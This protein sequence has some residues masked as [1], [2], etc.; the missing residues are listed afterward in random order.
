MD[1]YT[2]TMVTIITVCVFCSSLWVASWSL[3]FGGHNHDT[4]MITV[5]LK[6]YEKLEILATVLMN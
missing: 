1:T 5:M 6:L 4:T 2:K 3:I